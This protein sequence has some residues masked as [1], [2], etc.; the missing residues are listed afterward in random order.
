MAEHKFFMKNFYN[1]AKLSLVVDFSPQSFVPSRF[2]LRHSTAWN[3]RHAWLGPK[4]LLFST[5]FPTS[6]SLSDDGGLLHREAG[7]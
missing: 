5:K 1:F 7:L 3:L 6:L 4:V 2:F